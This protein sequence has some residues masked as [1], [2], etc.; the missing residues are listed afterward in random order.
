MVVNVG[1]CVSKE[2]EV[3]GTVHYFNKFKTKDKEFATQV[4]N[5]HVEPDPIFTSEKFIHSDEGLCGCK[6]GD[7]EAAHQALICLQNL[8]PFLAIKVV[9][10]HAS[11]TSVET[12]EAALPMAATRVR[13]VI[14]HICQTAQI[15]NRNGL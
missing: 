13:D 3:V 10:D 14:Q 6:Y 5:L 7:M 8:T 1:T 2:K 9:S 11:E 12:W 15:C 4:A